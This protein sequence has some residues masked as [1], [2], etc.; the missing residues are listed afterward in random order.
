MP[1]TLFSAIEH[2]RAN[3]LEEAEA[4]CREVLAREP[5]NAE[6]YA[7]LASVLEQ[8]GRP[9]EALAMYRQSVTLAPQDAE[10]QLSLGLVS[11]LLGDYGAG[12]R[13]YEWR[14]HRRASARASVP[15]AA[16]P[17]WDGSDP[18]GRTILVQCEPGIGDSV[19]FARYLPLLGGRGADVVLVCPRPLVRLFGSLPGVC[20]VAEGDPPPRADV[21][22]AIGS[23][24]L[25]FG[26]TPAT[27]PTFAAYLR[28]DARLA[29]TWR[30]RLRP[31]RAGGR[32]LVGIACGSDYAHSDHAESFI[33]P[34]Q[35]APLTE[36]P[37]VRFV[38]LQTCRTPAAR[39]IDGSTASF[40][41]DIDDVANTAALVAQLDLVIADG[42][43][44]VAHLAGALGKAC[45]TLVPFAP[46][47]RWALTGD[48][49]SWYPS[50][51]LFR[52]PARGDWASVAIELAQTIK[53]ELALSPAHLAA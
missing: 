5:G 4:A 27:I 48:D 24:P 32:K 36:L 46:D 18:R 22:V 26:T 1:G 7:C 15:G 8:L 43:T 9:A 10:A 35:L 45:W 34:D 42:T 11:L 29:A 51:R 39:V 41:P 6:A 44:Y 14:T 16:L 13:G 40:A 33:H 28:A 53:Q 50:M 17:R 12:W 37:G 3:R 25:M 31:L 49:S 2:R 23:L 52:Q 20:V 47:W 21:S 30:E 38:A 19:Q